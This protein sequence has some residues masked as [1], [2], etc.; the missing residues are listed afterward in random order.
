MQ[1]LEF[2]VIDGLLV[3][4]PAE[5]WTVVIFGFWLKADVVTP[6]YG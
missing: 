3:K 5:A 6:E 2:D 4:A 1:E